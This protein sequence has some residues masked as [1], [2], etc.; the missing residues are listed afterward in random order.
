[1]KKIGIVIVAA[2][3]ICVIGMSDFVYSQEDEWPAGTIGRGKQAKESEPAVSPQA[4]APVASQNPAQV[5]ITPDTNAAA[6]GAVDP[7]AMAAVFAQA[8]TQAMAGTDANMS[9]GQAEPNAEQPEG[10]WIKGLEQDVNRIE[11]TSDTQQW[12]S[13]IDNRAELARAVNAKVTE[14]LQFLRR[15]ADAEGA[16][17][18]A[19]AI[20]LLIASREKRLNELLKILEDETRQER[21]REREERRTRTTR[22]DRTDRTRERTSRLR[23]REDRTQ[24]APGAPGGYNPG[25]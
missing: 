7:N 15:L 9:A 8:Y 5:R 23:E 10:E 2:T 24:P 6:P 25:N 22:P 21:I 17:K 14:E 18:T 3:A 16:K 19:K 4:A 11:Q 1:M 13:R 20:D 12:Q